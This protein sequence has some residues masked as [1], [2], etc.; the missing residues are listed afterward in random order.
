MRVLYLKALWLLGSAAAVQT[1]S[2]NQSITLPEEPC[3]KVQYAFNQR[4]NPS[5]KTALACLKSVPLNT[6][7]DLQLLKELRSYWQ[8]Q[9]S[10]SWLKDPPP[11][12]DNPGVDIL[13][14]LDALSTKVGNG[15]Y[16]GEFDFALDLWN[17]VTS[18]RDDHFVYVPD[19]LNVFAFIRPMELIS[20]SSDGQTLPNVY[21]SS[22][23]DPLV[24]PLTVQRADLAL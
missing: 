12:Y 7:G 15:N 22:R 9:T 19:I 14:S 8:F 21:L 13:E 2:S 11:H 4:A 23:S 16:T 6:A 18:A 20:L 5:A 3:A 1:M 24:V 17:L 10:F